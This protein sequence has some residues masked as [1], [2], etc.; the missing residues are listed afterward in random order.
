MS[1][2]RILPVMLSGG[3][4]TRLCPV[5]RGKHLWQLQSGSYSGENAILRIDDNY[6]RLQ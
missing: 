1:E 5:S 6:G 3:S 2:S 4:G